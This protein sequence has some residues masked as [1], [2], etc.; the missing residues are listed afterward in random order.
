MNI[1]DC[2]TFGWPTAQY[3]VG[4]TYE[5]L[6][7]FSEDIPK[8]TEQEINAQWPLFQQSL[9]LKSYTKAIENRILEVVKSYSY[10]S[11]VSMA[12]YVTSTNPAWQAE[13]IAFVA[14]RDMVYEYGYSVLAAVEEGEPVPTL[15]EFIAGIPNWIP[16]N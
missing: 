4:E 15:E 9:L 1:S 16:P 12:T 5:S 6:Q 13:A 14:W 10:D 7:W 11:A 3:S 8:P 2:L